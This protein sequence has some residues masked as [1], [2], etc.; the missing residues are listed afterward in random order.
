[1]CMSLT[2]KI[3]ST[4]LF[5]QGCVN[6]EPTGPTKVEPPP[7]PVVTEEWVPMV[8][9]SDAEGDGSITFLFRDLSGRV[10]PAVATCVD[11]G[12][13]E[14]DGEVKIQQMKHKD[15]TV[16]TVACVEPPKSM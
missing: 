10:R 1:M 9:K 4:T 16:Y 14:R 3:F 12:P 15:L 8:A 7:P 11:A 2:I 5:F 6:T 13:Q